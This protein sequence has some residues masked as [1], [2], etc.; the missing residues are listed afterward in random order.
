MRAIVSI[1]STTLIGSLLLQCYLAIWHPSSF[2]RFAEFPVILLYTACI[3]SAAF[4]VLIVPGFIWLRRTHR[5]VSPPAG[6]IA[7][8][9]LGCLV[10]LLFMTLSHWPVRIGELVAGSVAG[11]VGVSIY[12]GLVFRRVV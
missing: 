2:G 11:A 8:L 5:S 10:M 3:A 6:F 1:L 7:G 9:A 4:L 12:A